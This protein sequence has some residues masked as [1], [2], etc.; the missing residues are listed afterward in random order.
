MLL[1]TEIIAGDHEFSTLLEAVLWT[2]PE[3]VDDSLSDCKCV[4]QID[5]SILHDI[6]GQTLGT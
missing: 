1:G 6:C 5:L 4:L 3:R 2:D